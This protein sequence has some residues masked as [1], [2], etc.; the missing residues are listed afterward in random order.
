MFIWTACVVM[1][2]SPLAAAS[3]GNNIRAQNKNDLLVFK[4][5]TPIHKE[6]QIDGCLIVFHIF[7]FNGYLYCYA[8]CTVLTKLLLFATHR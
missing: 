7:A 3:T 8:I 4:D 6:T 5:K 1:L 2:W